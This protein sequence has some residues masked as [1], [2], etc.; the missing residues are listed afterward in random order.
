[1]TK[2]RK[3]V[4]FNWALTGVVCSTRRSVTKMVYCSSPV[5]FSLRTASTT[6]GSATS[7]VSRTRSSL[8]Y[9]MN[10]FPIT[11]VRA[12]TWLKKVICTL[13]HWSWWWKLVSFSGFFSDT[14]NSFIMRAISGPAT[15]HLWSAATFCVRPTAPPLPSHKQCFVHV[16]GPLRCSRSCALSCW[17]LTCHW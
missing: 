8:L 5:F 10:G 6:S 2:E 4:S 1:M 9:S 16:L 13:L 3:L 7:L 15:I 14:W 11:L 17:L 12:L